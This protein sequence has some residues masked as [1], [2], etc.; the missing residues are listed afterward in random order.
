MPQRRQDAAAASNATTGAA[1]D[2]RRIEVRI[3][4]GPR[5]RRSAAARALRRTGSSAKRPESRIAGPTGIPGQA[6]R[7]RRVSR[8]GQE[9]PERRELPCRVGPGR[10]GDG[11]SPPPSPP[12]LAE[13]RPRRDD[14]LDIRLL[15]EEAT[16]DVAVAL[17]KAGAHE[18]LR[19]RGSGPAE[20]P[21]WTSSSHPFA[22]ATFRDTARKRY[23]QRVRRDQPDRR[24]RRAGSR[25]A[26]TRSTSSPQ[27]AVVVAGSAG[28]AGRGSTS[29]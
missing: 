13:L 19:G 9:E 2:P 26:A 22:C 25:R 16:D 24:T 21:R 29:T 20:A 27:R 10:T 6:P 12:P 7:R 3:A 5:G 1:P 17:H 14:G 11:G 8:L 15:W 23:E 4:L 28:G 18:A